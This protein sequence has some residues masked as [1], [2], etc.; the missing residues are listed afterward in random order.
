MRAVDQVSALSEDQGK[1]VSYISQ[2]YPMEY[3]VRKESIFWLEICFL[4]LY[5]KILIPS[6]RKPF[7]TLCI[8]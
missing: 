6:P 8:L 2:G 5:L 4:V 1:E 7:L 3:Y